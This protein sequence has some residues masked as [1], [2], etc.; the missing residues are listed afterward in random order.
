MA[1]S[2]SFRDFVREQFE[3]VAPVTTRPM[4][5]GLTFFHDG[6]AFALID[7]DRLYLKVD[8]SNRGDFEAAGCGPFLPFGDPAKPMAY[9]EL[10]GEVLEDSEALPTWLRK[11]FAV[12]AR[13]RPKASSKKGKR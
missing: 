10:P 11:A 9:Y 6:K 12:A 7:D 5:G 3:Q 1:V 8:D 4:F 2:P 13:T